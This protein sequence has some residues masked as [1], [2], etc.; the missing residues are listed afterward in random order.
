LPLFVAEVQRLG[1]EPAEPLGPPAVTLARPSR[2]LSRP[3]AGS[4]PR[5]HPS[6]SA[7]GVDDLDASDSLDELCELSEFGDVD[8]PGDEMDALMSDVE[9]A[10][11]ERWIEQLLHAHAAGGKI[12]PPPPLRTSL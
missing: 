7:H 6:P 5:R 12:P 11:T 4:W 1:R 2:L 3:R 9:A 10:E 8:A